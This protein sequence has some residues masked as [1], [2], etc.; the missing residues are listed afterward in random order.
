MA[1]SSSNSRFRTSVAGVTHEAE[2]RALAFPGGAWERDF[3]S[4]GFGSAFS[5]AN[6]DAIL[7]W[8][9]EY[10]SVADLSLFA[11]TRAFENGVDGRFHEVLVHGNLQ[12]N[13]PC[14]IHG[15]LMS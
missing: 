12:L 10:L 5:G 9:H 6:A 7:E 14:Q 11:G 4:D 13:F 15:E 2:P 3:A 8:H 1:R